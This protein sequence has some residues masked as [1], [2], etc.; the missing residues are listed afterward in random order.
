M[1]NTAYSLFY[2]SIGVNP[3]DVGLGYAATIS[4]STG[5]VVIAVCVSVFVF[6][7]ALWTNI[8]NRSW[9]RGAEERAEANRRAA[10][11]ILEQAG[12][13]QALKEAAKSDEATASV[14]LDAV[15]RH[16]AAAREAE[17]W[18]ERPPHSQRIPLLFAILILLLVLMPLAPLLAY[19]RADEVRR[20][21]EVSPVRVFGITVLA[22][23]ASHAAVRA[24]GKPGETVA[25][26]YLRSRDLLYLGRTNG[27]I[28]L[29]DSQSDEAIHV[30]ASLIV[31]RIGS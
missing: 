18:R 6:L 26:D 2:G 5:F 14:V 1:L 11:V 27:T 17:A 20:G 4:R 8:L 12:D 7:P 3:E 22:I 10:Q 30:P 9:R 24:T 15:G 31:L 19:P 29:Y 23:R 13:A 25:I 21:Q 28:V 16:M